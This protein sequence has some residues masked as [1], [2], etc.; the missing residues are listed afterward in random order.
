MEGL[1]RYRGVFGGVLFG[2]TFAFAFD[3]I[4]YRSLYPAEVGVVFTLLTILIMAMLTQIIRQTERKMGVYQ[5]T[6][7]VK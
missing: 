6:K 7:E 3:G 2:S 5:I 1:R 4:Q